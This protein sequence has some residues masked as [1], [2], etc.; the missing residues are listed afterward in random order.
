MVFNDILRKDSDKM[1][2]VI[3]KSPYVSSG[4]AVG[5]DYINYMAQRERVDKSINMKKVEIN[6]NYIATRPR[7]EKIGEHGLFASKDDVNLNKA[8]SDILNHHGTVW[9]PNSVGILYGHVSNIEGNKDLPSEH[10]IK[11]I[12]DEF[13][14]SVEWFKTGM[15]NMQKYQKSFSCTNDSSKSG[16]MY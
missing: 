10:L 13:N 9:L 6:L 3:F 5:G 7:V 14:T 1:S 4:K 15:G 12:A 16:I 11:R 2:K 8:R